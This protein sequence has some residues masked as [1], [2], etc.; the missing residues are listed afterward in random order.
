M[1][2]EKRTHSAI[3]PSCRGNG[4]LRVRQIIIQVWNWALGYAKTIDC[5]MC[6]NQ[7]ELVYEEPKIVPFSGRP[8]CPH[9]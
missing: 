1:N 4:Y 6:H 3:C 7:G 8:G 9:N 2:S 5:K